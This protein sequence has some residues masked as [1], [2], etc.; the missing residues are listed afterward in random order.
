[1]LPSHT[2]LAAS[3]QT[4]QGRDDWDEYKPTRVAQGFELARF[5]QHTRRSPLAVLMGD[6]NSAPDDQVLDLLRVAGHLRDAFAECNPRAAGYTYG[7][8]NNS[9]GPNGAGG[10]VEAAAPHAPALPSH[11]ASGGDGGSSSRRGQGHG[12][13]RGRSRSEDAVSVPLVDEEEGRASAWADSDVDPE[14]T[15]TLQDR[16]TRMDYILFSAARDGAALGDV[17]S[18][19]GEASPEEDGATH[20]LSSGG[21]GSSVGWSVRSCRIV[22]WRTPAGVS[23]SDHFGVAATFAFDAAGATAYPAPPAATACAVPRLATAG[24]GAGDRSDASPPVLMAS[25]A[26]APAQ[27]RSADSG[28]A[29]SPDH[30]LGVD[31]ATSPDRASVACGDGSPTS[32]RGVAS[33]ARRLTAGAGWEVHPKL[34]PAAHAQRAV[35]RGGGGSLPAL[36]AAPLVAGLDR[37]VS[38]LRECQAIIVS[39]LSDAQRRKG[40]HARRAWRA[41]LVMAAYGLVLAATAVAGSGAAGG[42]GDVVVTARGAEVHMPGGVGP[43]TPPNPA[44]APAGGDLVNSAASTALSALALVV[45][46][47]GAYATVELLLCWF[48]VGDEISG[49]EEVREQMEVCSVYRRALRSAASAS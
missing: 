26:A 6:L 10:P 11:S 45:P 7:A 46:I 42:G 28:A 43:A 1:M 22:R 35:Q 33:S 4:F 16:P 9:W 3:R 30:G 19:G 17:G 13:G 49:F 41:I 37:E 23:V 29:P 39:G 47:L 8:I 24:V 36:S 18:E 12:R 21:G 25:H 2:A 32:A 38:V 34:P 48:A 27:V 31:I 14:A 20:Y 44:P 15:H 40:G 5:V